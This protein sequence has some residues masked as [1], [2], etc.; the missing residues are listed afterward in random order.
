MT[1]ISV[2]AKQTDPDVVKFLEEALE[3]AR[4]GE[5]SGILLLEQDREG[6]TYTVAGAKNR[7]EIS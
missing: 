5:I 4:A 2:L 6:M 1:A 7:F 3:R